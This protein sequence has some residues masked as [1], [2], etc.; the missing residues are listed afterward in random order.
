MFSVPTVC[1]MRWYWFSL[2]PSSATTTDLVEPLV[3]TYTT[4]ELGYASVGRGRM[5]H[6]HGII[7]SQEN[8][9]MLIKATRKMEGIWEV[10]VKR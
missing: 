2:E 4:S 3:Q 1:P 6:H 10:S 8:A 9:R 5:W 7:P